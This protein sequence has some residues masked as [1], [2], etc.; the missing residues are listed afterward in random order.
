MKFLASLPTVTCTF[1][2]CSMGFL[3]GIMPYRSS[4]AGSSVRIG[5]AMLPFFCEAC[6]RE[7]EF[8]FEVGLLPLDAS[9]V[10]KPC[11]KCH[12]PLTVLPH[13]FDELSIF[14]K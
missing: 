11:G 1:E 6:D 5:S 2:A 14:R 12:E 13:A 9:L 4:A 10:T 3:T 8:L 7:Q